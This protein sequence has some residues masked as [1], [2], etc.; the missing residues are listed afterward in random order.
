MEK[1][2]EGQQAA[3]ARSPAPASPPACQPFDRPLSYRQVPVV[4]RYIKHFQSKGRPLTRRC[5]QVHGRGA[6]LAQPVH[7]LFY[8]PLHHKTGGR[9]GRRPRG[10]SG[11]GTSCTDGTLLETSA[12]QSAPP[13]N[14]GAHAQR[15]AGRCGC[16]CP[17]PAQA[18]PPPRAR[19]GARAWSDAGRCGPH[20]PPPA[21]PLPD[22]T[23]APPG[24]R[25]APLQ[26]MGQTIRRVDGKEGAPTAAA[27][28]CLHIQHPP[29]LFRHWGTQPNVP[30][31]SNPPVKFSPFAPC[32]ISSSSTRGAPLR[33]LP[34]GC[35]P[36]ALLDLQ[37]WR[38][39]EVS[40]GRAEGSR[41]A[42]H[43]S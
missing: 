8:G 15:G 39:W 19:T 29:A 35:L 31:P 22:L 32:L 11:G 21:P 23:G 25:A 16:T 27:P 1:L 30:S 7:V 26:R 3:P 10:H 4:H 13:A 18:Q 24:P 37:G 34:I 12:L 33:P 5:R 17:R 28:A 36:A 41:H 14:H 20:A 40:R 2:G 43:L 38:G 9:G 42:T 6:L